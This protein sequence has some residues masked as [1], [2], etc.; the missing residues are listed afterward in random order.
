MRGPWQP[1]GCCS[2]CWDWFASLGPFCGLLWIF[3][4]QDPHLCNLGLSPQNSGRL[5]WLHSGMLEMS[6]NISPFSSP[7]NLQPMSSPVM[8]YRYTSSPHHLWWVN[9]EAHILL[10][11]PEFLTLI[12]HCHSWLTNSI[13]GFLYHP[14]TCFPSV[15]LV[16]CVA[17]S[18]SICPWVL[19]SGSVFRKTKTKKDI[20]NFKDL[21]IG[22]GF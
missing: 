6:E 12:V 4:G 18:K 11:I 22:L 15:L 21:G 5:L 1:M 3:N 10:P 14:S 8:V 2:R 20:N 13:I 7:S 16:F 19:A 17:P 9:Y